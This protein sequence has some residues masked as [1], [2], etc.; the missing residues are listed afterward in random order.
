MR[1][2]GEM[3]N[4]LPRTPIIMHISVIKYIIDR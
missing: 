4:T 2:K 3:L 1:V